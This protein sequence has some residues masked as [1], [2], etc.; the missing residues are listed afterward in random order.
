MSPL[1]VSNPPEYRTDDRARL[2][3]TGITDLAMPFDGA[4]VLPRAPHADDAARLA[5]MRDL[6]HT[7]WLHY[8][9]LYPRAPRA[10]EAGPGLVFP[11]LRGFDGKPFVLGSTARAVA[12]KVIVLV[13]RGHTLLDDISVRGIFTKDPFYSPRYPDNASLSTIP[14][15]IVL[16]LDT[17]AGD[18]VLPS[19]A[20]NPGGETVTAPPFPVGEGFSPFTTD[21][22]AY[23]LLKAALEGRTLAGEV[24]GFDIAGHAIDAYALALA[25]GLDTTTPFGPEFQGVNDMLVQLVDAHGQPLDPDGAT[26]DAL[27]FDPFLHSMTTGAAGRPQGRAF[28][29]R[30][31]A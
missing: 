25:V 22:G 24:Y 11:T 19:G 20:P 8:S 7:D 27:H 23:V 9:Y 2:H 10:G 1:L 30:R 26:F 6:D 3:V 4:I 17:A 16:H 21:H 5:A 14:G 12:G 18:L 31:L 15:F 28:S 29:R 13:A